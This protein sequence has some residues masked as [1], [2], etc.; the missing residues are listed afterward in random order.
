MMTGINTL[1]WR[2]RDAARMNGVLNDPDVRPY[3]DEQGVGDADLSVAVA[4]P[5]NVLLMGDHGGC[6]FFPITPGIYEVHT[7]VAKAGRGAWTRDFVR[8]AVHWMFTRTPAGEIVTRIPSRHRGAV[9]AAEW[10]G[11]EF[12]YDLPQAVRFCGRTDDILIY[13]LRLQDWV[14]HAG[15]IED[16]GRKFHVQLCAEALRCGIGDAPHEDAAVHNRFVG[17]AVE[18]ARHGQLEK[19][20]LFYNVSAVIMRKPQIQIVAA[21]PPTIRMDLGDLR[22]WQDGIELLREARDVAS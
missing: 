19:G 8:A 14:L 2:E 6:L 3:I 16:I 1:I 5:Q 7:A 17:A 9:G 22:I 15:M 18:M 10:A 21:V 4:N 11:M 12:Q 20:A 13:A